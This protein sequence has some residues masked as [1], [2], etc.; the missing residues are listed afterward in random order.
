M[1]S[2]DF[3]GNGLGM[4]N[5]HAK[6]T[7]AAAA[8]EKAARP[9]RRAAREGALR[10]TSR[11]RPSPTRL[12][13]KTPRSGWSRA[14]ASSAASPRRAPTRSTP[15]ST[16]AARAPSRTPTA[17]SSSR[18]TAPRSPRAGASSR[19]TSSS[20]STS[21]RRASTATRTR[22]RRASA[23]SSTA[24][25][26]PSARRARRSAATSP[27]K[28]DADTFEAELS[29]L[30]V[31]S[32]ARSTR[33]SGSTCGLWHEYGITG[34]GGNWAWDDGDGRRSSRP[35][36]AYERPQCSACFIQSVEGRPHVAST[37]S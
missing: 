27:R 37:T 35:T 5:G 12:R 26:T 24:S 6:L 22:A 8:T 18:W 13:P 29:Y 23:R 15:S 28:A 14:C 16:S 9:A 32:T 33:R 10:P 34:S 3:G 25:R 20:P 17:A 2:S 31:T 21:A 11:S 36:N 19:P 1:A 7:R 30:L 4:R